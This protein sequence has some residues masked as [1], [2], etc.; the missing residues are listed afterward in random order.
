MTTVW[1]MLTI[2]ELADRHLLRD[3]LDV[4]GRPRQPLLVVDLDR[5]RDALPAATATAAGLA[6][7]MAVMVGVTRQ[8]VPPELG[9]LVDQLDMVVSAIDQPDH[10]VVVGDVD[11]VLASIDAAVTGCPMAALCLVALLRQTSVLPAG[12]G[13]LAESFAYSTLQAGPELA[14][15]LARRPPRSGRALGTPA[16]RLARGDARLEVTLAHSD[17]RNAFGQQMRDELVEALRLVDADDSITEVH[18]RGEGPAFCGGGDLDEFGTAPDPASAHLIR[19]A[20]SVAALLH[21]HRT[22]IHAHVHGACIG[23]GAELP[24]CAGRVS[25][26]PDAFFQLPEVSMGLVPGAG[27]TVSITQRIGRWRMAYLAL[28]GVRFDAFTARAWGLVDHVE[29]A[30]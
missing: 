15:W 7:R 22:R 29:A 28:S 3:E 13:L 26:R 18:I 10:R 23:A 5:S 12:T 30:G 9:P 14:R 11:H 19:T 24:A 16:I 8:P 17:R 21:R 25:A 27:G 1:R 6:G 2:A 4:C 20:R